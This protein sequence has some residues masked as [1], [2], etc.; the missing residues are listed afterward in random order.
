MPNPRTRTT[1]RIAAVALG[2]LALAAAGVLVI[3]IGVGLHKVD[4]SYVVAFTHRE[5]GSPAGA[6]GAFVAMIGGFLLIGGV[7]WFWSFCR[8]LRRRSGR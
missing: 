1:L 5:H 3:V 2:S 6:A 8:K 4:G 7:G